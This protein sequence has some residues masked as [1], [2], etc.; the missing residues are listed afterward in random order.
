MVWQYNHSKTFKTITKHIPKV[1]TSPTHAFKLTYVL[2]WQQNHSITQNDYK[3]YHK[4]QKKNQPQIFTCVMFGEIQERCFENHVTKAK[5]MQ[6]IPG[7]LD[8]WLAPDT[9]ISIKLTYVMIGQQKHKKPSR[10]IPQNETQSP[11]L[12]LSLHTY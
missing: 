5:K 6:P 12:N 1:K 10:N 8:G 2:I 7:R 11:K 4:T 3:T 9:T